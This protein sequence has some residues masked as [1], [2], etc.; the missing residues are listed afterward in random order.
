MHLESERISTNFIRYNTLPVYKDAIIR[1]VTSG[2]TFF[3]F[4]S[5]F[6]NVD[7]FLSHLKFGDEII[8]ASHLLDNGGYWLHWAI[9]DED[10]ELA[11]ENQYDE[12]QGVL[13]YLAYSLLAMLVSFLMII[14]SVD[15]IFIAILF[16]FSLLMSIFFIKELIDIGLS[17]LTE[18]VMNYQKEKNI[19]GDFFLMKK[20]IA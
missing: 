11:P 14:D 2:K 19:F 20:Y 9:L 13:K 10:N 4:Q 3:F 5:Q 16:L 12:G 8:V 18:S 17:P 1:L 6:D 7:R 15:S